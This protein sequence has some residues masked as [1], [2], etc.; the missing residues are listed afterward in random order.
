MLQSSFGEPR[1]QEQAHGR[2]AKFSADD[3]ASAG[4]SDKGNVSQSQPD[5]ASATTAISRLLSRCIACSLTR[6]MGEQPVLDDVASLPLA[7]AFE[8]AQALASGSGCAQSTPELL[9]LLD[10]AQRCVEAAALFSRNE[11]AED[12]ATPVMRYLLLPFMKA[13]ALHTRAPAREPAT[14]RAQLAAALSCYSAF[15]QRAAQYGLLGPAGRP[16]YAAEEADARPDPGAARASKIERFKRSRA[17]E[18][19]LQQL[20]R[21]RR[22]ADEEVWRTRQRM[23]VS[24]RQLAAARSAHSCAHSLTRLLRASR[25]LLPQAGTEGGPPGGV[26]GWDEEDERRLWELQLEG[27]AIRSLDARPLVAQELALLEHAAAAQQQGQVQPLQPL[28]QQRSGSSASGEQ[29]H[30]QQEQQR[31]MMDRLA[32]IA[33]QLSVTDARQAMRQQV[34]GCTAALA[35]PGLDMRARLLTPCCGTVTP[36]LLAAGV[37]AQPHPADADGGAAGRD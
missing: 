2:P 32:G 3:G 29:R 4:G 14:R 10:H 31:M 16:A 18:G 25:H 36:P 15:L 35:V 12:L 30:Q 9:A 19:L 37:P 1:G 22:D 5:V 33:G 27:A 6:A 7:A 21:R 13:E 24:A 20:G 23:H 34:R 26:G 17:L 11:D 28:Q 8:R